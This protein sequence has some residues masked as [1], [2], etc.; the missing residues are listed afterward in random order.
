MKSNTFPLTLRKLLDTTDLKETFRYM[1]KQSQ[2]YVAKCDRL[3]LKQ[4]LELYTPVV[5][6]LKQLP[7]VK[8]YKMPILVE[9]IRGID[10]CFLNPKYE[11][12]PVG[13]KP[14]GGPR[15]PKGYYNCNLRRHNKYFAFEWIPWAKVIDTPIVID[16]T[17]HKLRDVEILGEMLNQLTVGGFTE[18]ERKASLDILMKRLTETIQKK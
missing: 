3:L 17:A 6:E 11:A 15:P 13:L 14:W 4:V 10:I 5:E 12:P 18:E 1:Y 7:I 2:K 9:N 8:P 16:S